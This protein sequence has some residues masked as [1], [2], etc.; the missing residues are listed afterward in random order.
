MKRFIY[1]SLVITIAFSF[2]L[3]AEPKG[4]PVGSPGVKLGINF[5][6]T[7]IHVYKMTDTTNVIR[8][9][10]DS[11]IKKYSREY[12][13][14]LTERAPSSPDKGFHK[15][16][17]S[18]DS[19]K[20]KFTDGEAI[21]DFDS[22]LDNPGALTFEDLVFTSI[23]LGKDFTTN[24]S[25][26]GEVIA[27]EGERLDWLKNYINEEGKDLADSV[28]KHLWLD[29]I[30]MDRL[31]YVS[32]PK[33]LAYPAGSLQIGE[34]WKSKFEFM[35]NG[36]YYQDSAIAKITGTGGNEITIEAQLKQIEFSGKPGKFYNIKGQLVPVVKCV[37]SGTYKLILSSKGSIRKAEL[38]CN[39]DI[40]AKVGRD[41]FTEKIQSKVIWDLLKQY[42]YK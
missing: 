22:Q 15:I 17:V 24:Y 27:I 1:L 34:E 4:K 19:L 18:I 3:Q 41:L 33:K 29:G 6:A 37:G 10:S 26:Y 11:S 7:I 25:P 42:T 2:A 39:V 23:P 9:Y 14:F 28:K 35:I 13:F 38:I 12:D 36:L 21:F 32:D 31:K 5:P 8:Q 16:D 40:T 30:S 20:Y